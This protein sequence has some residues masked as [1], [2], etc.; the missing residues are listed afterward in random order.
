M[1]LLRQ[2]VFQTHTSEKNK[3]IFHFSICQISVSDLPLVRRTNLHLELFPRYVRFD[4]VTLNYLCHSYEYLFG[5]E[6]KRKWIKDQLEPIKRILGGSKLEIKCV[7]NQTGGSTFTDHNAFLSHIE[8]E[9]L[10]IIGTCHG[11]KLN[12]LFCSERDSAENIIESLL[13]MPAI[14]RCSTVD[15]YLTMTGRVVNLPVDVIAN[16]LS[17]ERHGAKKTKEERF[18]Q[19]LTTHD[20]IRIQNTKDIWELLKTVS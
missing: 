14:I 16:W 11:F 3:K 1:S 17:Y 15:L 4:A 2:I 5:I 7:I 9:L 18:L 20:R 8:N 19:I 13:Q 6:Y 10:P 12:A